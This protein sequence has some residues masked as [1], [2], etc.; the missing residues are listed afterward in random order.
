VDKT[1]EDD[2]LI[3]GC[4]GIVDAPETI[5]SARSCHRVR[6]NIPRVIFDAIREQ[7]FVFPLSVYYS[8]IRSVCFPMQ[9]DLKQAILSCAP[10]PYGVRA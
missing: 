3:T 10:A 6:G 4:A 5:G 1:L 9:G 2:V 8:G 7:F